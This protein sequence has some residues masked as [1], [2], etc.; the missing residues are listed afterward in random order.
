MS[1]DDDIDRTCADAGAVETSKEFEFPVKLTEAFWLCAHGGMTLAD[2][3]WMAKECVTEAAKAHHG[4]KKLAA[5]H[6]DVS[7]QTLWNIERGKHK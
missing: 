1:L 6:L 3:A 2:F 4:Q 7:A 5:K